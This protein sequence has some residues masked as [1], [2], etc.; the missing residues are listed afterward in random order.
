MVRLI[1]ISILITIVSCTKQQTNEKRTSK[2]DT[3]F[4]SQQSLGLVGGELRE[5]SGLVA[6]IIN[7]GYLWTHND[8]G[9]SASIYLL[10]E[11]GQVV[12]TCK[13]KNTVNRDWEDITIGPGP[14][15]G[16]NYIYVADIGDN[17]AMYS[18]K[19]LYRIKEPILTSNKIEVNEVDKLVFELPDGVRDAEAIMIDPITRYF[20]ISS[21]REHSVRL[22]E[23]KFPFISDTLRAVEVAKLPF[24]SIVAANISA[25]GRE[26]LMKNYKE[27]YYWKRDSLESIPSLLKKDPLQLNYKSEP[28]GEAIAWKRD[29][30]GF[31]TLSESEKGDGGNLYFYKRKQ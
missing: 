6:S 27:I 4:E 21:K 29:G 2:K 9:N 16:I 7:P 30:S 14:E 20:Y 24:T 8:S 28:Q 31:Y 17:N 13:L 12:M 25:D 22:Y 23:I 15:E 3:P 19:I 1:F 5:A 10:N 18:Y 11:K 26:V